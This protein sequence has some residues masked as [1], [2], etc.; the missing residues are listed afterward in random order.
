MGIFEAVR[1]AAAGAGDSPWYEPEVGAH[2]TA[3][4][5]HDVHRFYDENDARTRAVDDDVHRQ[6][7]LG[8]PGEGPEGSMAGSRLETGHHVKVNMD[9]PSQTWYATVI[10]PSYPHHSRDDVAFL[11]LGTEDRQVPHMLRQRFTHPEVQQHLRD[12]MDR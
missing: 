2:Y 1:R 7:G 4:N 10:P 11:H 6:T 5:M 3:G 12:T 8:R 9:Y